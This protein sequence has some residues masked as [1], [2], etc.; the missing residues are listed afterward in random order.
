[1]ALSPAQI[2]KAPPEPLDDV[3]LG[4]LRRPFAVP[5]PR[6]ADLEW[7]TEHRGPPRLDVTGE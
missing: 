5:H 3:G 4:E 6:D 7:L 2:R 1:M